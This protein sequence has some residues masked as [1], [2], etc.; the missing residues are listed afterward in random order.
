MFK[1]K[2]YLIDT[3]FSL[4]F[5]GS[6]VEK[7]A[8]IPCHHIDFNTHIQLHTY[9]HTHTDAIGEYV[10]L[11]TNF[12]QEKFVLITGTLMKKTQL[13]DTLKSHKINLSGVIF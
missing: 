2:N 4:T 5:F 7:S 9:I 13:L 3:N 11:F 1:N 6:V 10:D 8:R 12:V